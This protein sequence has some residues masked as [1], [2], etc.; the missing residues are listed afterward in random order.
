MSE[1]LE[2]KLD[3]AKATGEDSVAADAVTPT[4][5]AVKKRRGD[6]NQ[7]VNPNADDVEDDVKTPQGTNNTGLKESAF[8][9]ILE[10]LDLSEEFKTKVEAVFEATVAEKTRA[11]QEQ[12]E[13]QFEADLEESIDSVTRDM[14][15]KVDS[16][17]DYVV[18]NWLDENEVAVESAIKVE[19]AESLL[20]SLKGLVEQHNIQ[21]TDEEVD[22]LA[23]LEARLDESDAKYNEL[24][25]SM[26]EI[27][28]QKESLEREIALAEISE[29][30]TDT[31]ADKLAVLAEGISFDDVEEY[32]NKL[33]AI[34]ESYF[35][36]SAFMD[37]ADQAEMLEE[38]V[39]ETNTVKVLDESIARYSKLLDRHAK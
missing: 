20:D 38:E 2:N 6:V 3:E 12:L 13:A 10:G 18:E 14:V 31:Q 34:K 11:I 33:V 24:F 19:V 9:S 27:K 1:E 39:E 15:E 5:G 28:E 30:L 32:K 7:K 23:D 22:L 25:D 21:I 36:E 29:E 16:Y 26:I 8:G 17:L 4:G 35:T 37:K